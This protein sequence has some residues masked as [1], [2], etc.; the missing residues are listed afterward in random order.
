MKKYLGK[1]S[2]VMRC[3]YT[4]NKMV[5]TQNTTNQRHV[6]MQNSRAAIPSGGDARLYSHPEGQSDVFLHN[7]S[8]TIIARNLASWGSE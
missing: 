3:P 7:I 6:K 2:K 8:L 5:K 1:H 4:L